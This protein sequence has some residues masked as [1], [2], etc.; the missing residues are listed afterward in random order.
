VKIFYLAVSLVA[1]IVAIPFLAFGAG[2]FGSI[3][4]V[5]V[6]LANLLNI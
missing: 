4:D 3:Q 1:A 6:A 2:P 5:A